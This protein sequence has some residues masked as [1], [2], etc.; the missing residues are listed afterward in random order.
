MA[1]GRVEIVPSKNH[2]SAEPCSV[3]VASGR[4]HAELPADGADCAD[5][6]LAMARDGCPQVAWRVVPDHVAG[7][8]AQQL[9]AVVGKVAFEI[10]PPQAAATSI[11]TCST[12]PPPTGGSRPSSR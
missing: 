4:W 8:F 1:W 12:W 6:D 9:A 11:V 3:S 5:R 7:A 10:S 2:R